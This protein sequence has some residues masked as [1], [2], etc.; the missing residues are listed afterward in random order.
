MSDRK[1]LISLLLSGIDCT[2]L[3]PPIDYRLPGDLV[4][5]FYDARLRPNFY[6]GD[7]PTESYINGSVSILFG[8]KSKTKD[9]VLHSK[10]LVVFVDSIT[11]KD[12]GNLNLPVGGTSYDKKREFFTIKM[13]KDLQIAN[14]YTVFMEFNCSLKTD[15]TGIYLST[16][17]DANDK[18]V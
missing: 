15:L 13:T 14:N 17:Q 3:A 12:K 7:I 6:D 2:T 8:V 1:Q 4:P 10:T 16:Y 5:Y 18:P 9:I 11:V